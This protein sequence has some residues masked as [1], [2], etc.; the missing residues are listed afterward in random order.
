MIIGPFLD[1]TGLFIAEASI[2][3]HDIWFYF[4]PMLDICVTSVDWLKNINLASIIE[5]IRD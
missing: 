1:D 4:N 2:I 5:M 3:L